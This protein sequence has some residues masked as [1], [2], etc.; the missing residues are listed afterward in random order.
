MRFLSSTSQTLNLLKAIAQFLKARLVCSVRGAECMVLV[1]S[2][3]RLPYALILEM[4]SDY[5]FR[6]S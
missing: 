4:M 6:C 5:I 3:P 2:I 1:I